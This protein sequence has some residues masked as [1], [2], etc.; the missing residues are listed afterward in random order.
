MPEH[1]LLIGPG[2]GGGLLLVFPNV[3]KAVELTPKSTMKTT[4]SIVRLPHCVNRLR[5]C[6]VQVFFVS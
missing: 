3:V 5:G 6:I 2:V 1:Y 4:N